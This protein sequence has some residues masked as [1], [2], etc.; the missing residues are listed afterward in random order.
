MTTQ[1]G[2]RYALYWAPRPDASLAALGARWLGH[3][4]ISAA[5]AKR[6]AVDGFSDERLE[7]I[8]ASPRLYGLHATLKPPFRLAADSDE[9]ALRAACDQITRGIRP[10]TVPALRLSLFDG[11]LALV[12]SAPCPALDDLAA[13][14]VTEFDNFRQP[15]SET[16]LARRRAAGLTPRE[17]EHLSRWGYPYVLDSFRFHITLTDRLDPAEAEQLHPI[18]SALFT[19]AI[20]QPFTVDDVTLFV[21]AE[22][23]L[24]FFQQQRFALRGSRPC[25][26]P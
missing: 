5:L 25:R 8:T 12:P 22:P 14:C 19:P 6:I 26:E 17:E 16:E 3:D 20:G 21:Q 7:R 23:G 24:P 18:L 15:A 1:H 9:A 4:A 2:K 10:V 11:F 13:R